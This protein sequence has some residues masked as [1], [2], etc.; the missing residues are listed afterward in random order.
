MKQ[1]RQCTD[2]KVARSRNHFYTETQ[3]Y[4]PFLLLSA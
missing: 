1:D 4:V 2:N 3:Q